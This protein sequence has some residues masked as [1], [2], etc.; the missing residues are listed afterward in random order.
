MEL[1]V[2]NNVSVHMLANYLASIR[3]RYVIYVLYHEKIKLF[4]KA[5]RFNRPLRSVLRNI[6][7]VD[8]LKRLSFL[9]NHV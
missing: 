1:L 6:M 5:V 2:K 7:T 9:Y 3:A 8:V 4:V